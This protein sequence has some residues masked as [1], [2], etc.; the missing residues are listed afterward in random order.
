MLFPKLSIEI[1]PVNKSII[2]IIMR[3]EEAPIYKLSRSQTQQI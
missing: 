2:Y 1:A 3:K